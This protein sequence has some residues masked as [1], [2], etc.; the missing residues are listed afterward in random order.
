METI[1][2]ANDQFANKIE[3]TKQSF[4]KMGGENCNFDFNAIYFHLVTFKPYKE[5]R[6]Q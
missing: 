3:R 5:S 4:A 1:M 2:N 6:N